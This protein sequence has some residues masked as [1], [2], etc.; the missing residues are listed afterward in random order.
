MPPKKLSLI[1]EKLKSNIWKAD[2]SF[3]DRYGRL[4][5]EIITGQYRWDRKMHAKKA[6]D[7]VTPKRLYTFANNL[8][9]T[10]HMM[11]LWV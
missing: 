2:S 7:S 8:F 3:A 9:R 6:I 10:N 5:S 4:Q 11:V 1:K